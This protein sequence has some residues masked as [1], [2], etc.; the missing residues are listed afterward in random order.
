MSDTVID[1]AVRDH[2]A[3]I[4]LSRPDAMN[5]LNAA[6]RGA[7]AQAF[8]QATA[9]DDVRCVVLT[10][11]G[12]RAFCA[13]LDLKEL[14][15]A[16]PQAIL[17]EADP[18]D[19]LTACRKPIICA[20]N[21]VAITGG[22]EIVLGCDIIIASEGARFADTHARVGIIPGW[23]LSQKLSRTIGIYRAKQ[24]SLTGNYLDAA[25]AER[26]G[27]VNMVVPADELLVQAARL[28]ADIVTVPVDMAQ[29]Y[30]KL[31]DDGYGMTFAAGL[32]L[33]DERSTAHAATQDADAIEARRRGVLERGR[34]QKAA[35]SAG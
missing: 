17:A 33:E 13:G 27:L 25:T 23:G 5:A 35:E 16:G 20:V 9:D 8:A 32:V 11:A 10:G 28:A 34:A 15:V 19:A 6:L 3:W 12:E 21:G 31:I 7:L 2:V 24:L 4:T 30:K 29:S 26:W 1:Y 18:V 22:F 14:G